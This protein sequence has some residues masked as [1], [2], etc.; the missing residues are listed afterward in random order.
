MVSRILRTAI[1]EAL[2]GN[3]TL[4]TKVVPVYHKVPDGA[5]KPFIEI[6]G[7]SE[8][9]DNGNKDVKKHETIVPIAVRTSS[10]GGDGGD[11]YA[12]L[13]SEQI[14]ALLI[15][16][17]TLTGYTIVNNSIAGSLSD[18]REFGNEYQSNKFI[19]FQFYIIKN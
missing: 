2:Q 12:D 10:I 11:L 6:I 7:Q 14:E 19:N 1:F 4:N 13:I 15:D 18:N 8:N 16:N 3:V 5:V 9:S 17:L